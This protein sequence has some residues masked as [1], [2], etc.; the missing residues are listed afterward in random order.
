MTEL[1]FLVNI[2]TN[3]KKFC[4]ELS[5]SQKTITYISVD[6]RENVFVVLK[7][8]LDFTE[9]AVSFLAQQGSMDQDVSQSATVLYTRLVI[10][11]LA[12]H[13]GLRSVNIKIKL[14]FF[15]TY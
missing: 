9:K 5:L 6:S 1:Y 12:A 10:S 2:N 13:Y 4:F 8:A 11:L 3:K 14:W 7:N 15:I